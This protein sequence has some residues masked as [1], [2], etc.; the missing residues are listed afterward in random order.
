M[1]GGQVA[2]R[3]FLLQTLVALL[4]VILDMGQIESLRLEPATNEDKTDFLI[5]YRDGRKKAVQVKSSKNQIGLPSVRTWARNLKGDLIADEY[6][7]CLIGPCSGEITKLPEVEGVKLPTPRSLDVK[8]MLEQASHRL[9]VYLHKTGLGVGS[10]TIRELIVEALVGKLSTYS[11]SGSPITG[12]D[13]ANVFKEWISF[14]EEQAIRDVKKRYGD[15]T[16]TD[17]DA[18]KEY[19]AQFDRAALQDSLRGCWN[20][21]RFG[22]SLGEL[23]ELLN[24]GKVGG[25]VVTKRRADYGCEKWQNG[26]TDVYHEVRR[27][28]ELYSSLVKTGEIDEATCGCKCSHSVVEDFEDRKRRIT[29]LLNEVLADA[30]IP[31]I[32]DG[33][34]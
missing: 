18:L 21:R 12:D 2:T 15:G 14:A 20:Y 6:E 16:L 19:R 4:D 33:L 31:P 29:L 10:P 26:L 3:G 11:T 1:N 7:L 32:R 27:L 24:T 9:D 22:E 5:E 30:D 34:G 13:M 23:I 28:R 25:Q 8:G 17:V